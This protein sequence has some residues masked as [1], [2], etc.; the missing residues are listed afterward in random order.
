MSKPFIKTIPRENI[1]HQL[2]SCGIILYFQLDYKF[3]E[4]TDVAEIALG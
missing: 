4:V 3:H 2:A 1:V